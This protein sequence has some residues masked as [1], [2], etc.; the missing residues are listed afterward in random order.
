MNKVY[1]TEQD[2]Y[3]IA[4]FLND[5]QFDWVVIA[6]A[7][8]EQYGFIFNQFNLY[9]DKYWLY[10]VEVDEDVIYVNRISLED[11]KSTK[12]IC[13]FREF[14][15]E[16]TKSR[17]EGPSDVF[18]RYQYAHERHDNLYYSTL[19]V[20]E[21]IVYV[22]MKSLEERVEE[23]VEPRVRE[24]STKR[25]YTK[26]NSDRIYSLTQCIRKYAKHVNHCKHVIKCEHWQ[27][28]GHLRH[29]KNGKVVYVKPYEKGTNKEAPLKDKIYKI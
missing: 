23:I 6:G 8:L 29:Y 3:D 14:V 13:T 11:R 1:V 15:K 17:K 24:T 9:V 4:H 16:Y 2:M 18:G 19:H 12:T 7:Y 20:I 28:R 27:V 21:F 26:S 5:G 22:I 10:K 25:Q